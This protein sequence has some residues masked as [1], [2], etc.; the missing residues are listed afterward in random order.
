MKTYSI[1]G[2]M[3]RLRNPRNGKSSPNAAI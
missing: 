2:R 3:G 1:V